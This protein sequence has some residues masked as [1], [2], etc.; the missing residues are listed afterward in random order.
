MTDLAF[1]LIFSE[2]DY[3]VLSSE[4]IWK[5]KT[6]RIKSDSENEVVNVFTSMNVESLLYFPPVSSE[7]KSMKMKYVSKVLVV[8]GVFWEAGSLSTVVLEKGRRL[9]NVA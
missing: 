3:V 1:K 2:R 9:A 5:Q 8:D 7:N 6:Y 4:W